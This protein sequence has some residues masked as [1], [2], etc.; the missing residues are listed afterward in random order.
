MVL[1]L[2]K[3]VFSIGFWMA[4]FASIVFLNTVWALTH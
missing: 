2:R 4:I 1:K 3:V